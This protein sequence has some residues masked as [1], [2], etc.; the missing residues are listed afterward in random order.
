VSQ[1]E[2]W[3]RDVTSRKLYVEWIVT[4]SYCLFDAQTSDNPNCVQFHPLYTDVGQKITIPRLAE[5]YKIFHLF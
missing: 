5:F 2:N 4:K 1:H 3:L